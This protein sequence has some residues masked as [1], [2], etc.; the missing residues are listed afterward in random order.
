MKRRRFGRHL[1]WLSLL[2]GMLLAASSSLWAQE[3]RANSAPTATVENT[4]IVA[5]VGQPVV[6]SGTVVD[7]D[8]DAIT[9]SSTSG[10]VIINGDGTWSWSGT[11][12]AAAQSVEVTFSDGLGAG[13]LVSFSVVAQA[14]DGPSA[15]FSG[16]GEPVA[17]GTSALVQFTNP[18]SP[19]LTYSY[20]CDNDGIFELEGSS[21]AQFF[22][23][24]GS[25]GSYTVTG[26]VQAADGASASYTAT[27]VVEDAAVAAADEVQPLVSVTLVI[28]EIDY[29][30]PST[31]TAE[32]VEIKNVSASA[33][34]LD[35][36]TLVFINGSGGGAAVYDTIELP[37]VS[38]AAGDYY[39]V[40]ADGSTVANC[41][42]DDS[43]DSNFIQ[44]GAPDAV[45]LLLGST[46]VDAV[47]YEGD[48][49]APYTEGTGTGLEDP[50]TTGSDNL[51]I[52]RL[53]DGIDTDT[54]NVDLSLRCITPGATNSSE[55]TGCQS[56]PPPTPTPPPPTGASLV[57]NEV[58]Y[59][60]DNTDTA[61][62]VEIK[63]V[64][65]SAV[66]LDPYSVVL[67]NGN[68]GGAA[69]Y[70]TIDLP[71][72][73]LAAGDYYVICANATTVNNCDL[74]DG[75]DT[76]FIQNGA[77][78]AVAI[79]LAGAIVDT[80]SYEGDTSGSYT[81][82]TGSG[83]EDNPLIANSGISR[84]PDGA[85]TDSNSF[86]F[87]PRCAT[88]GATNS[89]ATSDCANV[90]PPPPPTTVRIREIQGAAQVPPLLG[91]LVQNVPGIVTGIKGNG[92]FMQDPEP[93]ADDGTS[94]GIFV[95]TNSAPT[96]AM[97][98]SVLV[99]GSVTEYF[100]LTQ[101]SN[102]Q[103]SIQSSG[104][105]LPAPIVIGGGGRIPPTTV[106]D[107]DGNTTYDPATDG[108]DF[109]ESLEGMRVQVNNA[110]VVGPTNN[111]GEIAFVSD[112]G[113]YA[114]TLT[115]RGGIVIQPGDFNPERIFLDDG[116][117]FPTPQVNV[118]DVF[119]A[120]IIGPLDFTF[121]NYKIQPTEALVVTPGNL[122]QETAAPA[123]SPDELSVAS[124]N[125]ENLN[126]LD[127][128]AKVG[129]LAGLIVYNLGAPDIIGVQEIQD[130]DGELNS[131]TV[132]ASASAQR[133]IDAIA[134]LGGPTYAFRDIAPVNNED[135]GA[136]G[137]NI[138]VGFL[139]RPDRVTF[140]DRPGGG[141]TVATGVQMGA[142]G[143]ELTYS[144][145]RIDPTNGAF[146]DSR[147]PLA[148]EFIFQG[149]KVF[150]IVNHFNSKGGDDAL[151]DEHQPRVLSSEAQRV[152]Q[153]QVVNGF[154]S[155]LL[156]LDPSARVV[157]LGDL[158]DF[159]FSTPV[160]IVAGSILTNLINA[161]PLPEQ[162]T[163][164]FDGNSQ[165]LDNMLI[166][167]GLAGITTT[168]DIVHA[169]AEYAASIQASDH[170]P[171]LARFMLPQPNTPP[172]VSVAQPEVI[173]NEGDVA[174]NGVTIFDA[175]NNVTSVA[176][177]IGTVTENAGVWTW[178]SPTT[179]GPFGTGVTIT[180]T[181][182]FGA[183]AE[184][185]FNLSVNNVPPLVSAGTPVTV[186]RNEPVN[187]A[188]SFSD[189]GVNDAPFTISWDFGDG[190]TDPSGT[191]TPVHAYAL[192]GVYT[193]TLYVTD[194]DSGVGTGTVEITVLNRPP[195]CDAA[196]PSTAS[197]W[198]PNH[199][200]E[201]VSVLQVI[202][203]EGDALTIAITSIFQDE[204]VN[205]LDDGDTSP[206]GQG[207][208]TPVAEIRAERWGEGNGRF[209]HISFT[210]SDPRGGSCAGGFVV[211][212]PLSRNPNDIEVDDGP[213]YDSTLP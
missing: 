206:D 149:N 28:N 118:G 207:I 116:I 140:V 210:A 158:N 49:G 169:N 73:S 132:D 67:V 167:G 152:Q 44:N 33:I 61:E 50:G 191:L 19:D 90:T 190:V 92:F 122:P 120:P 163:Y 213:I 157:V 145:G 173:V 45:G 112:N 106:I 24:F 63:N 57:I 185:T 99:A 166:S 36:Y 174:S 204:P 202:D 46:V 144:P 8:N 128:V 194:K 187:F 211:Y 20:D 1:L 205:G 70:D 178:T 180:V 48:T 138:R 23:V 77:P 5:G 86:D 76:N 75:P 193:A 115:T 137:G 12:E 143:V 182:S 203:P 97:G 21:S 134:G 188:G 103:V 208:G 98:D 195:V 125:V 43:P 26:R 162:Y 168:F 175:E 111:F 42:L 114:S 87:S 197:L 65:A 91:Q 80:V 53:P 117:T 93:D 155:S 170:D 136:P 139:Y 156:S 109:Y 100:R 52:S 135:G 199:Q 88:P 34:D 39:V 121:D 18:S 58:D 72:V 146:A 127:N 60:Q 3:N 110:R 38:L 4:V 165:V 107:D 196:M 32:F 82:G 131:G 153:A 47:S 102:P 40:C 7:A 55:T 176:A 94:E 69:I 179:D 74:D 41:D 189:P 84:L 119:S 37:A 22:C 133:L 10:A 35:P 142:T 66:N 9:V 129:G 209:Y 2:F 78:D 11:A 83:L 186:Y 161:L 96:V 51:G 126:A 54:N 201:P 154:V 27:I 181:D 130:N 30:Q 64:T 6:N 31:D 105:P 14:A 29:D 141:S 95:F 123:S 17:V 79:T 89:T 164:V 183:S 198:P 71:A 150:I 85:D 124:F 184:A 25:A 15:T 148:G 81:E 108:I 104:N 172:T 113:A 101:I 192:D 177:T 56:T 147:K 13:A 160:Q 171:L 200:F 159:P 16:P 68:A 62:F 212:V 59:D 151:Y